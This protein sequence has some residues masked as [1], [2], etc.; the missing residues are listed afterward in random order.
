M[1]YMVNDTLTIGKKIFEVQKGDLNQADL[2]FYIDNP[3]VYSAL[4]T[5]NETPS[6]KEIEELMTGMDHVKQL[7]LSIETNGGLIDPLIVRAGDNVVLEGNSRLAA[8]RLLCRIDPIKWGM[9]KC[10]ILPA[11]I[12][13][14]S[15][16]ALLGQYHI[17]GRKD[18][19]PFEQA[20]YLYRRQL[21]TR[22]PVESMAKELGITS[23]DAKKFI[24]VYKFM[25]ENDDLTPDRWSY[26]EEYLKNREVKK[27]RENDVQKQLDKVV[28]EAV[29]TGEIRQATEMRQLGEVLKASSKSKKGKRLVEQIISKEVSIV[30]AHETLEVSGQINETISK[31]E[32][33]QNMINDN[34]FEKTVASSTKETKDKALFIIKRIDKRLSSLLKKLEQDGNHS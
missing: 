5:H 30:D 4:R 6:Q 3:R 8:Y 28:F 32:K 1:A 23:G 33:F 14:A 22:Y 12:D 34:D 29:K 9:V 19:S 7:K 25:I 17:V 27:F 20:G 15:I 13:D 2:K 16:F 11:D 18:W 26:Y 21:E 10:T 24:S 31:L